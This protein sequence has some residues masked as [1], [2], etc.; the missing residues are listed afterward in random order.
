MSTEIQQL[1]D[2]LKKQP[3][4]S[5]FNLQN[6]DRADSFMI[7][8]LDCFCETPLTKYLENHKNEYNIFEGSG[9]CTYIKK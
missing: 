1:N 6:I 8:S 2:W 5:L 9:C 4:G 3:C 7:S